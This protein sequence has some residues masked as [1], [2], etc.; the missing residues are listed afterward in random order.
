MERTKTE[1]SNPRIVNNATI[2]FDG[3]RELNKNRAN[4]RTRI[5]IFQDFL[6][7]PSAGR[8][9]FPYLCCHVFAFGATRWLGDF[10]RLVE[11]R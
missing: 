2:H 5:Q 6:Y 9:P 1:P 4:F 11:I 7:F 3:F 10:G 8:S